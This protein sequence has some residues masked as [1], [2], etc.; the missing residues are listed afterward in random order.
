M[1]TIGKIGSLEVD[2]V[3]LKTNEKIYYQVCATIKDEKTRERELR[4]PESIPD[5][6]PKY[7]L[8]TDQTIFNG[9]SETRVKNIMDFLLKT[10]A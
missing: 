4:P 5:N 9:Y 6:Y 2:F 8:T 10:S 3:A 1:V 7:I